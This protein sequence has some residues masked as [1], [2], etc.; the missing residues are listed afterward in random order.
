ML[1]YCG[2]H[3]DGCLGYRGTTAGDPA[4]LE[5]LASRTGQAAKDWV[6]LGCQPAD[7][8]F[9]ATFCAGCKIRACAIE[10][11]VPNCAACQGY[12]GC[13]QLH[14]FIRAESDEV[15][16]TMALLRER[17]LARQAG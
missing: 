14:D 7:Q 11:G 10:R 13:A 8:P 4:L 2:I 9:L 6:C 5:Q 12:E 17:F 1:G 16:R 15:V 3:C